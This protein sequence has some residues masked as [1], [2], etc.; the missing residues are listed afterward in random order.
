MADNQP[1][2]T[3]EAGDRNRDQRLVRRQLAARDQRHLD[4]T[5]RTGRVPRARRSR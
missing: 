4:R 1:R 3:R 2:R 5:E